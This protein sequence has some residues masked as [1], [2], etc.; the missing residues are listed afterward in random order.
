MLVAP[1]IPPNHG[2]VVVDVAEGRFIVDA[3]IL[4]H[5]PLPLGDTPATI[6]H[7]AWGV[8]TFTDD[9]GRTRI[10]WYPFHTP[11]GMDCRIESIGASEGDFRELHEATRGWSAFNYSLCIRLVEGERLFGFWF[12]Q[13]GERTA[14]GEQRFE[15]VDEA[16]RQ[17]V[18]WEEV[19][20]SPDH[21][22]AIPADRPVPPPPGSATAA[23]AG[24]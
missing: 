14:E 5:E 2:T 16:E 22:A 1:D 23:R 8:R 24:G 9:T 7:F 13:Y 6:D 21:V 18:L 3:S 4:H 15:L 20:F 11:D 12:G 19:G 17:R 10:R